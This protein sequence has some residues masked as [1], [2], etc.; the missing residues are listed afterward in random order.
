M[1]Y[2]NIHDLFENFEWEKRTRRE[3]DTLVVDGDMPMVC[4]ECL[5]PFRRARFDAEERI[6]CPTCGEAFRPVS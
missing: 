3:G 4:P 5:K 2:Y 1:G 6:L